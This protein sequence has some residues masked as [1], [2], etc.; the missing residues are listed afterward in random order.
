MMDSNRYLTTSRAT[1]D[2]GCS[3]ND[4]RRN[5]AKTTGTEKL[6]IVWASAG[7][8]GNKSNV[9]YVVFSFCSANVSL[10]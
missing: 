6:C 5:R 2:R 1:I 10:S 4:R 9:L 3:W 8:T 7:E